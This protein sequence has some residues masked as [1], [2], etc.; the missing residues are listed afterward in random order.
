MDPANVESSSPTP[1]S[2]AMDFDATAQA[3]TEPEPAAG[4]PRLDAQTLV[5]RMVAAGE[6]PKPALMKNIIAAGDSAVAP[7]ISV[8]RTDPRGWPE[9]A[10]LE[11]AMGL[12]SVLRPPAAIPELIQIIRRY[13]EESGESAA[14]FLGTFGAVAFE[15]LLDVCRDPAVT[16]YPRTNAISAAIGAASDDPSMR[17]RLADVIRPM[18]ADAIGRL[19]QVRKAATSAKRNHSDDETPK[20]E[21]DLAEFSEIDNEPGDD[22]IEDDSQDSRT[23]RGKRAPDMHDDVF[24]FVNDL[25]ALADPGARGLI[26]TA[27]AEDMVDTFLIDEAFVERQYQRGGEPVRVVPDCLETSQADYRNNHDRPS[28]PPRPLPL[29]A[30]QPERRSEQ[31]VSPPPLTLH[32]PVRNVGP[33]LGRN[34]QCWCG[35]GKKYK[36]CHLGKDTRN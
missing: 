4:Q 7:L 5:D 26:Q 12:L 19:R 1:P 10:P 29:R 20:D 2:A 21:A 22:H 3:T 34:E 6:W 11:H 16:G 14:R 31:D 25:A 33:A 17:T 18:L 28:P 27:F 30:P 24:F 9:E 13:D 15:P 36:K 32:K 35:S 8:L 23:E